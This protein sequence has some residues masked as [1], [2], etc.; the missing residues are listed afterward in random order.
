M[1]IFF[2]DLLKNNKHVIGTILQIPSPEILEILKYAGLDFVVIDNEHCCA[3][4]EQTLSL[5]R[6][7]D[8]CGLAAIVR[9]PEITENSIK[10]ILDMGASGLLIPSVSS[11]EDVEK[12]LKYSY[13]SP[14][15]NRGACPYV[16]ANCYGAKDVST[17]YER[18]NS[19]VYI[20]VTLEGLD[21][22]R[23]M[24][25]II[26]MD[27]IDSIGVGKVDLAVAL[28][29]P[30]QVNHPKVLEMLKKISK[31]AG[32]NGKS[33]TDFIFRPEDIDNV[34]KDASRIILVNIP[35]VILYEQYKKFIEIVRQK[36]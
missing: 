13:F 11:K 1:K 18:A 34:D 26:R 33:M 21:G 10:K 3:T 19:N 17:Y 28:G 29:V 12:I 6:A 5:I 30:G 20:N 7:A 16:R 35:E 2:K 14:K 36:L 8:A 27:G 25:E 9:I 24:E 22:I 23:N 15:G 31:I 32:E 4:Y